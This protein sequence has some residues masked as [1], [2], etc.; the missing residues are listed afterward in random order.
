MKLE[1]LLVDLVPY[2]KRF[3]DLEHKW[4]NSEAA[5]WGDMG[6]RVIFT[7][8]DLRRRRDE[9]QSHEGPVKSVPL[10]I[11]TKDGT[12]IGGIFI[13]WIDAWHR[14]ASLG[15][16]IGEP[17]YW[18]GGYGTDALLLTVDYAFTWLDLRRLWLMTMSLNERVLRQMAK[19]GFA[20]EAIQREATV[21]DGQPFDVVRYGMLREEWPGYAALAERLDLYARAAALKGD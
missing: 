2:G 12:P 16:V 11:Q 8:A 15:A 7:R 21:A 6:D 20:Q 9:W 18:G 17:D 19:V 13:S 14:T 5:F 10:G 1:G 3:I 4:E